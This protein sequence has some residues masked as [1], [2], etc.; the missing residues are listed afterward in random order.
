MKLIKIAVLLFLLRYQINPDE[1]LVGKN[2]NLSFINI[3]VWV[4]ANFLFFYS[5]SGGVG[6]QIKRGC[7]ESKQRK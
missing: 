7:S 4:Y 3:Y 1:S 5:A 2:Y 6:I